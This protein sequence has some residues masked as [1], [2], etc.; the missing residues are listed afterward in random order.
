MQLD[1]M[2]EKPRKFYVGQL[3]R[4]KLARVKFWSSFFKSSQGV[5]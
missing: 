4:A 2:G 1:V 5:G 3:D